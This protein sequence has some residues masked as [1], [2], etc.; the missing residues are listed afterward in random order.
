LRDTVDG[1]SNEFCRSDKTPEELIFEL[2][3][4]SNKDEAAVG[5]LIAVLK[6]YGIHD[7]D[8]RLRKMMEVRV[9][10]IVVGNFLAYGFFCVRKKRLEMSVF[11]V[12]FCEIL[13]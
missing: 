1:L 4:I 7:N 11:C 13:L 10:F 12:F 9:F 8:P 5:K 3:R 6:S 2:F